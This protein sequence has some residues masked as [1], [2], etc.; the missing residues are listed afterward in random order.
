MLEAIRQ[1]AQGWIAKII[2]GLLVLSFAVWGLNS[3]LDGGGK[4]KPMATVNGS[5]ISQKDFQDALQ[6]QQEALGQD[7]AADHTVLRKQV[8]EQLLNTRLLLVAAQKNGMQILPGQI[9]SF[10]AGL[11][12]FQEDGRFSQARFDAWLRGRGLSQ[13]YFVEMV[14]QDMLLKQVQFAYGE[15][16]TV[17]QSAADRLGRLLSQQREVQERVFDVNAYLAG[18]Q[19]DDAAVEAEYNTNRQAYATPAQ[20][21]VK[22][23][24]LSSQVLSDLIQVD[25]KSA[26]QFYESNRTR[27]QQPEQRRASHILILADAGMDAKAREAARAKATQL[28]QEVQ[29]QPARF[30]DLAKEHSQDPLSAVQGGDLGAFTRE[31]MVKPFADAAFGMKEG[32]IVGP[33][34]TEFGYHLIR[35]DGVIAGGGLGFEQVKGEILDELRKQQA[36]RQYAESAERFSN[37]VYEQP[38]TLEPAAQ[39]FKLQVQ[40][41]GWLSRKEAQPQFLG[42]PRLVDALFDRDVLE[43]KHNTEAVEVSP[44]VLVAA[45]VLE[46]RPEG[47]RPL[48]EVAQEI[49]LKLAVKAAGEKAVAAGQ[50]ALKEAQAGQPPAG[51]SAPMT[52]SR[53]QPMQ[54]SPEAIKTIFRA[55]AGKLPA[56]AGMAS[57]DGYRLYR[58][59]QV[60]EADTKPEM[61]RQVRRD[62]QRLT[63]Q[64]ELRAFLEYTRSKSEIVVDQ[65]L[66]E[67]KDE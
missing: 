66:V 35:L 21:R 10:I 24:V 56:Y 30:A 62:L 34:E 22:Y 39:E 40:E 47:M 5:E 13:A 31:S 67:G 14:R 55:D 59:D 50:Q 38:E 54:L 60:S 17:P 36:Q 12:P 52:V 8:M 51:M 19:I 33:V 45:R 2:L 1:H 46:H 9:E 58:I 28:L 15:G 16:A 64:E 18:V 48:P 29:A 11:E 4:I 61:L 53:M 3:Y 23:V 20:V 42:H 65:K 44:G 57:P 37:L 43:N 27:F 25:E 41:S 63:A 26:R 7:A 6:Q 32:E 49:R